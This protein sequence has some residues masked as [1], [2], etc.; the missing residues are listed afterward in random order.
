MD[1]VEK[2]VRDGVEALLNAFWDIA[3]HLSHITAKIP[4]DLI[5]FNI[6]IPQAEYEENPSYYEFPHAI[7]VFFARPCGEIHVSIHREPD[8]SVMFVA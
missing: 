5:G 7:F 8:E 2:N 6:Q 4:A 3:P 1:F